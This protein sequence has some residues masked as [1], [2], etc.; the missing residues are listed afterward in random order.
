[1]EISW[2]I[3]CRV[4]DTVPGAIGALLLLMPGYSLAMMAII[5][6]FFPRHDLVPLTGAERNMGST[7]TAY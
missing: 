6:M 1:M 5:G 3:H 4:S 2:W 7:V